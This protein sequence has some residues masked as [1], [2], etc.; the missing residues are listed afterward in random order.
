MLGR[1][2][3]LAAHEHGLAI[4]YFVYGSESGKPGKFTATTTIETSKLD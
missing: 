3:G 2:D 1:H 4:A